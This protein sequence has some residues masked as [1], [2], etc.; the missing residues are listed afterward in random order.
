[1]ALEVGVICPVRKPMSYNGG[2]SF[3]QCKAV[4]ILVYANKCS[5]LQALPSI[6]WLLLAVLWFDLN[7]TAMQFVIVFWRE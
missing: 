7:A 4:Q 1:M 6:C 5:Y 2:Y 3:Y